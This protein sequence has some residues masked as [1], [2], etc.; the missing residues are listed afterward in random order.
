[1]VVAADGMIVGKTLGRAVGTGTSIDDHSTNLANAKLFAAA[2]K[3]LEA[4]R[5]I[6]DKAFLA[7]PSAIGFTQDELQ[8]IAEVAD[9]AFAAV[10]GK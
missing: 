7:I 8:E 6:R 1:M 10:K 5:T 3:L 9:E 4:I 2:P